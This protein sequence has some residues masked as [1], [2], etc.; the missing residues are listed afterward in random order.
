MGFAAGWTGSR[1]DWSG[2]EPKKAK[3][4][5]GSSG[6]T[7]FW[8]YSG[9]QSGLRELIETGSPPRMNTGAI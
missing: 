6:G 5:S 2:N 8:R 3:T 7:A 1:I 9:Q 4:G